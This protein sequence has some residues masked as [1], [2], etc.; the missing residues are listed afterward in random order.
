MYQPSNFIS[1]DLQINSWADL[2]PYFDALTN[3][4]VK[5]S[6]DLGQLIIHYSE[7]LSVFHEQNAWSYI[8]MTRETSNKE[9]LERHE[10]FATKIA[11]ELEKA[12]NGVE[13]M[14]VNH[15]AFDTLPD[16]RFGQLKK[17]LKRE[18]ELY[19]D[20]NVF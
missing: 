20:E 7:T 14:I 6:E 1:T 3:S 10:L 17:R 16:E 13:K 18:L 4:Q 8:N 9:Y 5:N 12:A 11:P 19:R 15:P 2:K